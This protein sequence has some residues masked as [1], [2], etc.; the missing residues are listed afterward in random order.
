MKAHVFRNAGSRGM[1]KSG[2]TFRRTA[3][4]FSLLEMLA[5][6]VIA[7]VLLAVLFGAVQQARAKAASAKCMSQ[8]RAVGN[9][10]FLY[11]AD[12]NG[13][14][15]TLFSGTTPAPTARY[16]VYLLAP[17]MG[18][19]ENQGIGITTLSCPAKSTQPKSASM[20]GVNY[21]T[22]IALNKGQSGASYLDIGARRLAGTVDSRAFLLAD[23]TGAA[24]Y[25]PMIWTLTKDEDE[26]GV[27]DSNASFPFNRL[28]FRHGKKAN[29]FLLNG[30]VITLTSKQWGENE[31]NIWGKPQ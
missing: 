6:I 2:Q 14:F 29:F 28:D 7:G 19:A 16:W 18:L 1:H 30:S 27:N 23:A 25:S 4:A 15:P 3:R 26:D 12:N 9:T 31:N 13:I 17:Y 22:I 24:V 11:A 10:F 21:P 8:L 5:T 20:Y